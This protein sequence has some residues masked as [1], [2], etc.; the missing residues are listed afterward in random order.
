V[1]NVTL[2][3][4]YLPAGRDA[5]TVRTQKYI[6]VNLRCRRHPCHP[7]SNKCFRAFYFPKLTNFDG[8]FIRIP[9]TF[10]QIK[11]ILS[12]KTVG[13][14]GCGGLGSNCAVALARVGIGRLI[15]ADFDVVSRDNLNRQYFFMDQVGKPKVIA[16]KEIIARIDPGVKVEDHSVKLT[17]SNIPGLFSA[18]DVIVEALDLAQEKELLIETVLTDLPDKPLVAGLG[19][20]GYGMNDSIHVRRA[21]NLYICGDEISEIAP[22]LPPI[23]PRVGIVA[24]MQANVVLELLLAGRK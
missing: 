13:I 6:R 5:K 21:D 19:M 14:A 1:K 18:C 4:T 16:L 17:R 15:L 9:L 10:E 12:L 24:N 2:P 20:A 23:A 22:D 3:Q 11:S 7:C 8:R